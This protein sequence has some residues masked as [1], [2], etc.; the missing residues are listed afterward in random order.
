MTAIE[1]LLADVL[2]EAR[3]L[4]QD[5]HSFVE[6]KRT[7]IEGYGATGPRKSYEVSDGGLPPLGDLAVDA[8]I[9]TGHHPALRDRAPSERPTVRELR[10]EAVRAAD[11]A[12]LRAR[13]QLDEAG[14][15]GGPVG[16]SPGQQ[17]GES[18]SGDVP[19]RGTAGPLQSCGCSG[20]LSSPSVGE[21]GSSTVGDG[22]GSGAASAAPDHAPGDGPGVA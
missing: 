16:S 14:R 20:P 7:G 9:M 8:A 12:R 3:M 2:A 21:R 22:G 18:D 6:L 10:E 19:V 1:E 4:R 15:S 13:Q 5:V 17:S 11:Q